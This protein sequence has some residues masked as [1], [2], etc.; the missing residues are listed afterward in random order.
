MSGVSDLT[1][2]RLDVLL[3]R[4]QHDGR[5]PSVVGGVVR[6]GEL[7]WT[8]AV[9]GVDEVVPGPDVQYRIGS[10]TK[11]L[12]ALAVLQL[13]DEGALDLN[14]R[15]DEHLPG[16]R[17]GDRT[18]R[19]LL[20]HDTG[21]HSEPAGSWWERTP[22]GTFDELAAGLSEDDAPFVPGATFHY[23]NVAFGLL[24]EVV[25]RHR[26]APWFDV[27]RE[28]ILEPLGMTRTT[29]LPEAPH[30][31]RL[32]RA[33]LRRHADRRAV[34]RR[35]RDGAGRSGVEHGRG[36]RALRGVPRGR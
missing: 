13:R 3:A 31:T 15:L 36:P 16:I 22:G 29:Y 30:A 19:G 35:R 6:D 34:V 9:G 32:Q 10:I 33:P 12:V 11:T 14:D 2:R 17:Y 7:V 8:G 26:G 28:R 25:S 20:S 1:A 24:G 4:E 21:M 27:V 23:T 18:L 5:L